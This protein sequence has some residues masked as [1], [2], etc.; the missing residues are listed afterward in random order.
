[1]A[2][3]NPDLIVALRQSAQRL[4]GDVSYQSA[5]IRDGDWEHELIAR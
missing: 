4:C 1:M 5:L 3:A 2:H